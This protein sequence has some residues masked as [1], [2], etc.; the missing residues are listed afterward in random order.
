MKS[1]QSQI[2]NGSDMM[3]NRSHFTCAD[4]APDYGDYFYEGC[5]RA[6]DM[7]NSSN[8]SQVIWPFKSRCP[9]FL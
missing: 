3:N 4:K 7:L 2:Q 5:E 9:I 1:V 6:V 8:P